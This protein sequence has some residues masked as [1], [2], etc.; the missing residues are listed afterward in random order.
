MEV[1]YIKLMFTGNGLPHATCVHYTPLKLKCQYCFTV[2][3]YIYIYIVDVYCAWTSWSAVS[4][5]YLL[6][7]LQAGSIT[8]YKSPLACCVCNS[9]STF[10]HL[11]VVSLFSKIQSI[12]AMNNGVFIT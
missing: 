12:C 1:S 11:S 2:H 6:C 5:V 3:I 8:K 9:Q 7:I 4:V 10:Y